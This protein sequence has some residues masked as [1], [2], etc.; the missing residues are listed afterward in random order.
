MKPRFLDT[1]VLLR[2]FTRDDEE[3]DRAA[4][5]LLT[6]VEQGQERVETLPTVIFETVFTLQRFYQVPRPR[7][8]ALLLPIVRLRG[9]HLPGKTLLQD[10]LDLYVAQPK[11][12][13]A[14]A[15]HAVYL[16]KGKEA[17]IY[18]WDTDFDDLEGITRLEPTAA[19]QE[20][21]PPTS[22]SR[23]KRSIND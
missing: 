17:E 7:I 19:P 1:N 3:K 6:R 14:D 16:R 10:A 12:S 5:A 8:R 21:P 11:L 20:P 9:L 22:T 13:F 4:L 23:L 2:Y 15:Y 18:S